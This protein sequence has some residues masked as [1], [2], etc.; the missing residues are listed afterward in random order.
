MSTELDDRIR[1][2]VHTIAH[3]AADPIPW[4]DLS[5]PRNAPEPV[6]PR[7]R[8]LVAAAVALALVLGGA[9]VAFAVRNRSG[10]ISTTSH[11]SVIHSVFEFSQSSRGCPTSRHSGPLDADRAHI[12]TWYDAAGQRYRS[13]MTYPDGSTLDEVYLGIPEHPSAVFRFGRVFTRGQWKLGPGCVGVTAGPVL[14]QPWAST[15]TPNGVG[16]PVAGT[17]KDS[18][19][20]TSW[21]RRS[22]GT[23]TVASGNDTPQ[24]ATETLTYFVEPRTARLLEIRYRLQSPTVGEFTSRLVKIREGRVDAP[25]GIFSTRFY[26]S[27]KRP[28][29]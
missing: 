8:N 5:V 24:L 29:P 12:D 7:Y 21:R 22:S 4:S 10:E 9:A 13:R 20:R 18:K 27:S 1:A 11:P 28:S 17:V 16:R 26:R 6:H 14:P 19:G 15:S 25:R 3:T 23:M 2:T